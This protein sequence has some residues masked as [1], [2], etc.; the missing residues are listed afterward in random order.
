MPSLSASRIISETTSDHLPVLTRTGDLVNERHQLSLR[1]F[2]HS[3]VALVQKVS[4][5]SG[6][7]H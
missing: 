7:H 4:H 3:P 6:R 2:F 5:D 1:F